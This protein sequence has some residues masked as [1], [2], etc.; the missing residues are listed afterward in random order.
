MPILNIKKI[1][2]VNTQKLVGSH[3]VT[4]IL[5]NRTKMSAHIILPCAI[6]GYNIGKMSMR[7][8]VKGLIAGALIGCLIA[9]KINRKFNPLPLLNTREVIDRRSGNI[10]EATPRDCKSIEIINSFTLLK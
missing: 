7:S 5:N 10:R 6:I 4:Q 3:T 2:I 9:S 1:Q 8:P